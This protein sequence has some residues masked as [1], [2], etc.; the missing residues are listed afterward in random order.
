MIL[1]TQG[2]HQHLNMEIIPVQ[3]LA[4]LR[5]RKKPQATYWTQREV[6]AAVRAEGYSVVTTMTR[7]MGT[8][9]FQELR[10]N[11]TQQEHQEGMLL[12]ETVYDAGL[13]SIY[14]P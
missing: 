3:H 7:V 8:D 11:Q 10:L 2:R 14:I 4:D 12:V 9:T 6:D 5:Q 1:T 13:K